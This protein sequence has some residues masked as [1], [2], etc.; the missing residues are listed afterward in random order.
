[1]PFQRIVHGYPGGGAIERGLLHLIEKSHPVAGAC[2][3]IY[4]QAGHFLRLGLGVAAADGEIASGWA[5]LV[6]RI[7]FRHFL[8]LTAVTERC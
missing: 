5:R 6:R 8:S 3:Q 1:M 7:M 2:H 4:L